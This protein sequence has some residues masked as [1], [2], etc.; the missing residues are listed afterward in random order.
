M[1]WLTGGLMS[2]IVEFKSVFLSFG[3]RDIL[4]DVSFQIPDGKI[5]LLIGKSGAGKTSVL[6][7]VTGQLQPSSGYVSVNDSLF[8]Y[9]DKQNIYS[10]RKSLGMVFQSGALFS[11]LTV[12]QNV[13][14]PLQEHTNFSNEKME[15]LV[16]VALGEV[17]LTDAK[18]LY[19]WELSG[20]MVKRAAIARASILKPG[21]MLYDEPLA[22]QDPVTAVKLVDLIKK[23]SGS[24]L[25]VSHNINIMLKFVDYI[26]M[27]DQGKLL[28]AGNKKQILSCDI[29][30]VKSFVRPVEDYFD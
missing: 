19:P 28:F 22:G 25:I 3:N 23:R 7:L 8:N 30:Q 10:L 16:D 9:N 20:G 18:S 24:A 11:D 13:M 15:Y 29:P 21:L 4:K 5:S 12:F 2:G 1:C 17:E 27:L 6:R 14:L 26:I